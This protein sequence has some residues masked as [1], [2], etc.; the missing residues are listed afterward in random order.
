MSLDDAASERQHA[1]DYADALDMIAPRPVYASRHDSSSV[2]EC[3]GCGK[4]Y[5]GI[6]NWSAHWCQQGGS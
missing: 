1:S 6:P 2:V 4:N 3:L 5:Y